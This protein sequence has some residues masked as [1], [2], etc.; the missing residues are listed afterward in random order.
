MGCCE[1]LEYEYLRV[2]CISNKVAENLEARDAEKEDRF[3]RGFK[4]LVQRTSLAVA[5]S[6][7]GIGTRAVLIDRYD[8]YLLHDCVFVASVGLAIRL[9]SAS[10]VGLEP[11]QKDKSRLKQLIDF[12]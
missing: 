7:T 12:I 10:L 1:F 8:E 2:N 11:K 3:M 4:Y 6:A 9:Y 5:A